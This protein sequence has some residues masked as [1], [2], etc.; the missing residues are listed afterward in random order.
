MGFRKS[1]VW[2]WG[3]LV[4]G[5][6]YRIQEF[7]GDEEK[8][9]RSKNGNVSVEREGKAAESVGMKAGPEEAGAGWDGRVEGPGA[10]NGRAF[11]GESWLVKQGR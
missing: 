1:I 6:E 10:G 2:G 3:W 4:L 11:P 7:G 8:L 5:K 9:E